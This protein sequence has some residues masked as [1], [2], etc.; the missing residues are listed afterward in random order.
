MW[1][2][3]EKRKKRAIALF[4]P[5]VAGLLLSAILTSALSGCAPTQMSPAEERKHFGETYTPKSIIIPQ[6]EDTFATVSMSWEDGQMKHKL[7]VDKSTP[8]KEWLNDH[9]KGRFIVTWTDGDRTVGGFDAPFN[10]LRISSDQKTL[11][12]EGNAD[13]GEEAYADIYKHRDSWGLTWAYD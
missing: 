5:L 10:L 6:L 2:L 7:V 4:V 12:Y 3:W 11:S 8:L 9:P 13:C 1:D